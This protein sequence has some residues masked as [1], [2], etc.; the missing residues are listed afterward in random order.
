[1]GGCLARNREDT[2]SEHFRSKKER[3]GILHSTSYLVD[4]AH[5][6]F[7]PGIRKGEAVLLSPQIDTVSPRC[8]AKVVCKS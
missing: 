6:V 1:M 7:S 5:T 4:P 8:L 2:A 3:D